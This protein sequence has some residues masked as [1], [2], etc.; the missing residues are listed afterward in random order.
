MLI[1]L[2][3]HLLLWQYFTKGDKNFRI[4]KSTGAATAS[5]AASTVFV[6]SA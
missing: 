4:R 2:Q 5:F 3:K 1:Q 6:T